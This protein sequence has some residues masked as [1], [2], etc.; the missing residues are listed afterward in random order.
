M[1]S[2]NR[3]TAREKEVAGLVAAGKSNRA[4][5]AALW[6]SE[7]TVENHV[8]SILAKL[9]TDSRVGIANA[10]LRAGPQRGPDAP[11]S[12][13]GSDLP[14]QLTS[15]VNRDVELAELASLLG[16]HRLVTLTG[17]GGVG[18]TRTALQAAANPL[19]SFRDGVWF[20]ELAPLLT[21]A[22]IPSAVALALGLQ[23]ET[24]GESFENVAQ[25]L[26]SHQALLLIDNC[27]HLI[28]DC[29]ELIAR[30]LQRCPD[31][32]VLATSRE[33][34]SID[35]EECYRLPSL[36]VPAP[37]NVKGLRA[38]AAMEFSAIQL[39]VER[40]R[41]ADK[42]FVLSD[43]NAGTVAAICR[44]LDGI[45]LAIELAATRVAILSPR[46]LNEGL[47]ERFSIL[48]DHGRNTIPRHKTLAA[49]IDWSHEL[50]NER[51]RRLFRRLG[52]F[53]SSFA[54][55][56]ALAV[57][58]GEDLNEERVFEGLASLVDKSLVLS[59]PVG[60]VFRF[61]LLE[62]TRAYAFEKLRSAG[63][64]DL[65]ARRL[66]RHLCTS[67]SR[68]RGLS[69]ETARV[70]DVHDAFSIELDNIR[71]SLHRA[72]N[73]KEAVAA[74][75]LLADIGQCWNFL[76]L[77]D[78]GIA[79]IDRS[80][81]ALGDDEPVLRARL[82][83]TL[84]EVL[85]NHQQH[86]RAREFAVR[87]LALARVC[88]NERV[89]AHAISRF[90][91]STANYGDLRSAASAYAEGQAIPDLPLPLRLRL[92][93]S[94]SELLTN[95]GDF[96]GAVQVIEQVCQQH[97]ALGNQREESV[98][99][100]NLA[101]QLYA[102]GRTRD[103]IVTA[104]EIL[105]ALGGSGRL[106]LLGDLAGYLV[107][108]NELHE[109]FALAR[110]AMRERATSTRDTVNLSI[111]I[112]HLAL[113][114]A[115]AGDLPRA[116]KLGSYSYAAERYGYPRSLLEATTRARLLEILKERL[117]GDDVESLSAL[118]S[119]LSFDAAIALA[120]EAASQ[121]AAQDF[122]EIEY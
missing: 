43:E 85:A 80:L 102:S 29:G 57:A 44:R 39:F 69:D 91:N 113:A 110:E 16:R 48:T 8:R 67:F 90:V 83:I 24:K 108:A 112:G 111:V 15:F 114:L 89:F 14:R 100:I 21:G 49:L 81:A 34:L 42:R 63:E 1:V 56:G 12:L 18:K 45:P 122:R 119:A 107:D 38:S 32:T 61:R 121:A 31:V 52:I 94:R 65:L 98:W 105:P 36:G 10:L 117:S 72:F 58:A 37:E 33:P 59:E 87:G 5:A 6:L 35:G 106:L 96:A 40:A 41:T 53:A 64:V 97:R 116:A 99:T 88:G 86:V 92:L 20:V 30:I 109:T 118:G 82:S 47:D 2:T 73:G 54:L 23:L 4:I 9:D 7:R 3:L 103:A 68:L 77:N 11:E 22:Y 13:R 84:S 55:E 26:R 71:A 95:Q 75:R 25:A 120:F 104:R 115:L 27:E 93:G 74:S 51:E 46:Q 50:L 76:Y 101:E 28:V 70:S 62:S 78:E 19:R 79:W 17:S 60:D 66:L